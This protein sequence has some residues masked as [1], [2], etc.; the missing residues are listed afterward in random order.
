MLTVLLGPP[1]CGR[2][3]RVLECIRL[4]AE[5]R[6]YSILLAPESG[7]HQLERRLLMH[8]GNRASEYAGVSTFSKLTE[9]VLSATGRNPKTL[10]AGGRVLT[11]Y[12]ALSDVADGLSYYRGASRSELLRRLLELAEELKTAGILPEQLAT[13][14][15]GAKL[16]DLALIYARYCRLCAEG[17]LDPADRLAIAM[18]ALPESGLLKGKAVFLDGFDVLTGQ[19]YAALSA[20]LRCAESLTVALPM[21][22]DTQLY[23][24]QRKTLARLRRLAERCSVPFG[25]EMLAAPAG[26]R[27]S[28]LEYLTKNLLDYHAPRM[29]GGA[30]VDLFLAGDPAEECELAAALLRQ[31][32]LDGCRLRDT[33]VVCGDL[34]DYGPLLEEAFHRYEVP[35]FLSV[36]EDILQKPA[37][38]AALGGIAALEDGLSPERVLDWLRT[39]LCG[40]SGDGLYRL[41]NYVLQWKIAGADWKK[42]FTLPTCGY[43]NPAS[44]EDLRMTV[45]EDVRAAVMALLTPLDADLRRCRTGADF[46]AALVRHLDGLG[47]EEGFS[48]RAERLRALGLRR[49]AEEYAQ[50]WGI[51]DSALAQFSGAAGEMPM[52]RHS[53][54]RLL[55][56]MLAQYDVSSIPVSLDSVQAVSLERMAVGPIRHLL[57]VGAREGLLPADKTP[58]SLLTERDR[59]MLEG[60]GI[61][62][63][64]NAEDRAFQ[65]QLAVVRALA[66]PAESLTVIT[67]RR[68]PDGTE[69]RVSYLVRRM[70]ALM[71]LPEQSAEKTLAN[72]RLTAKKPAFG[73]ACTAAETGGRGERAAALCWFGGAE[74]A[75]LRQLREYAVGPRGPI[76]DPTLVRRLYGGQVRLTASRLERLSACRFAHFMQYGLKA[77]PRRE[78]RLGAPEAGTFV[79][80]IVEHAVRDLCEGRE[81]DPAAASAHWTEEYLRTL[82]RPDTARQTVLCEGIGNLAAR[83]TENAWEEI[84][85]SEFRPRFFELSFG[86]GGLPP[87]TLQKDGVPVEITGKIDRVDVW[88]DGGK[89]YLKV[90]DYKTGSKSFRLSDMLE[91][92]NLQL[93]LYLLMLRQ[94]GEETRKRLGL[95]PDT[96]P[97]AALY[98]PAKAPYAVCPAGTGATE[99]RALLDKELRRIGL[100]LD[101]P[102]I[103]AALENDGEFRFLPVRLKRDGGWTADSHVATQE[104]LARLLQLTERKT[105][106]AADLLLHGDVE[107]RPYEDGQENVC[108]YCDFRD[109]C[110]FDPT[111]KKDRFRRLPHLPEAQVHEALAARETEEV[112]EPCS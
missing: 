90:I 11:M 69:C 50:L 55:R 66:A 9:D 43:D 34:T 32:M 38:Q 31:K 37:L 112:T 79:H 27:L 89:T 61:E 87:L 49:E 23:A 78:A 84:L 65:Q 45:V 77:K 95:P 75:F 51:L 104:Q 26:T 80:Y 22:E 20:I 88:E 83:V 7:S 48:V 91:G 15:D 107:A 99:L 25:T 93:F 102:R 97:A 52:D 74:S 36:K 42:P 105:L 109:A 24:E 103:A 76:P 12:R 21:G 6:E 33:A 13:A 58:D 63:T 19:K 85:A 111:M 14:A 53:F 82:S 56:L 59:I 40:L 110:H 54:L 92:I 71:P 18:E 3:G 100:V 96:A 17:A 8:C 94:T 106:E 47:L 30:G 10:D 4:R 64:Q 101:D 70:Q 2:T 67:P 73:L 5:R 86:T 44:D 57:L 81:T 68:L 46:S 62:L 28:S 72:L 35:L 108:R 29:E 41:E 1:G 16:Q 98:L 39:G 60:A